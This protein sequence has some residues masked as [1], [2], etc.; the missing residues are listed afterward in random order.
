VAIFVRILFLLNDRSR[1]YIF[2][3]LNERKCTNLFQG[4]SLHLSW[5]AL[6][7]QFSILPQSIHKKCL[8]LGK[9]AVCQAFGVSDKVIICNMHFLQMF[10]SKKAG[11]AAFRITPIEVML[12][13]SLL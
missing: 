11:Y 4:G 8:Q 1:T 6:L 12:F 9:A 7:D 13:P 10:N 2:G 5:E 3:W